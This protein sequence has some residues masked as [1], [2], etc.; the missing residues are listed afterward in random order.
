MVGGIPAFIGF[1]NDT[2]IFNHPLSGYQNPVDPVRFRNTGE[3]VMGKTLFTLGPFQDLPGIRKPRISS[4]QQTM[5]QRTRII[6]KIAH[7]D[8]RGRIL[9]NPAAD[10]LCLS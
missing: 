8:N 9:M 2:G 6:I 3:P 4:R 10:D 5:G 1:P 7:E